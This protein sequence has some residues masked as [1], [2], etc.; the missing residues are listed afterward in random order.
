MVF[1]FNC[2]IECIKKKKLSIQKYTKQLDKKWTKFIEK[3]TYFTTW[4]RPKS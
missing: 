2:K 3:E 4:K 1:P